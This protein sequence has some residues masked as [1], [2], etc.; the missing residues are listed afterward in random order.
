MN[1]AKIIAGL[2]R[3]DARALRV[4]V[5]RYA[6][7]LWTVAAGY[8]PEHAGFN[9]H[10]VEECAGDAFLQLAAF[11]ER[12]DARKG[13]LKTYLCTLAR[14]KAIDRFRRSGRCPEECWEPR[15]VEVLADEITPFASS[16]DADYQALYEAMD[17]LPAPTRE[18]LMR[19]YFL[20]QKP[21]LISE[22]MGIDVKEVENR[23]YRGKATLAKKLKSSPHAA[24]GSPL[25]REEGLR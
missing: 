9:A 25:E 18:V 3:K 5:D 21:A 23:L 2:K 14:N 13:S 8:L 11:P 22:A 7:L 20:E 1:D 24:A 15:A 19:R 17:K 16:S 12:Y 10:D 4:L 6:R